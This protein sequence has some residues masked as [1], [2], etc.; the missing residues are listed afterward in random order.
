M[1]NSNRNLPVPSLDPSFF[2]VDMHLKVERCFRNVIYFSKNVLSRSGHLWVLLILNTIQIC[3]LK[4]LQQEMPQKGPEICYKYLAQL[5]QTRQSPPLKL[6][7]RCYSPWVNRPQVLST[8]QSQI[9]KVKILSSTYPRQCR[10]L[11]LATTVQL[12]VVNTN[13][14]NWTVTRSWS[15]L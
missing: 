2:L 8:I 11:A 3:C 6:F 5:L 15:Y 1:E 14:L 9:H 7:Y 10:A 4:K 12:T 13:E